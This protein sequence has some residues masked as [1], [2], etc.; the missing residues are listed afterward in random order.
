M[1]IRNQFG[2]FLGAAAGPF[3]WVTSALN[4]ELL[5]ARK[6]M[7]LVHKLCLADVQVQFEGDAVLVLSAMQGQGADNSVF[8]PIINA[9]RGILM[10]WS[11]SKTSHVP[12]EG[13][14]LAHC[15]AR[16]GLNSAQRWCGSRSLRI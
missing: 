16:L 1:V 12:R 15:L 2:E 3:E 9:M 14:S 5:A 13:N 8:G 10:Q 4:A 11:S 6:A 7:L